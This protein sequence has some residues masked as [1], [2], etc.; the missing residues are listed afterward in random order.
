M[1]IAVEIHSLSPKRSLRQVLS[2]MWDPINILNAF[3][4]VKIS[5]TEKQGETSVVQATNGVRNNSTGKE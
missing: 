5:T 4:L 1:S 3:R 2:L